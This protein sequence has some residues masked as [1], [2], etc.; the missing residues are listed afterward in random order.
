MGVFRWFNGMIQI[1]L[2]SA[3]L[4]K[5]ML[6]L[7]NAGI[8]LHGLDPVNDLTIR[9]CVFRRDYR[10]VKT[11]C[12]RMGDS[13]RIVRLF[14][15][16]WAAK[17]LINRPVLFGGIV[18]LLLLT[19]FLPTKIYFVEV[20]GN[21]AVP[22]ALILEKADEC[23]IGFGASRREIRSEKMKNSLLDAIP[24]LQWAGINTRGCV[25]VISVREKAATEVKPV[26]PP[27]SSIVASRDGVIVGC[28][29]E[30]GNALCKIG[31]AVKAGDLLVSG[32]TDCGLSIR[33]TRSVAEIY[34]Q[35]SR[36]LSVISPEEYTQR[37]GEVESKTRYALLIGKK[38]IN[39]YKDSGILGGTC[40]KMSTVNNLTLPGGFQLPVALVEERLIWFDSEPSALEAETA[41][42]IL[43]S[44]AEEYLHQQM[45]AGKILRKEQK[46]VRENDI[47]YFLGQYSCLEMIG[48]EQSEEI[49]GNYGKSD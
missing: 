47:Y 12:R 49:L 24:Q 20:E 28:T 38:R 33:A 42:E 40:G 23:G 48:R 31:Q 45:L 21:V 39:F 35:T 2:T 36:K 32:Y 43:C 16:H 27:A 5:T 46:T 8:G 3:D 30:Q 18:L 19:L 34:G 7:T 44:F 15:L 29:V 37:M 22:T 41:E 4:Y 25:A 11:I 14:G 9:F 26:E 1:E 10:K 17:G 6:Q 13:L